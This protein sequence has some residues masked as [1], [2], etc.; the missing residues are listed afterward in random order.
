MR[1]VKICDAIMG[2]GKSQSAI[3]YMNDHPD[4]RFIYITPY[5]DEARRIK[6]GC[7]DLNFVEPR[8]DLGKYGFSKILHTKALLEERANITTTH[9]A[10][11][12]YTEEIADLIRNGG[13]TLMIDEAVDVF[14]EV[15]YSEGDVQLFL[16]SGYFT[17]EDGR[18]QFNGQEYTGSRLSD[19]YNMIRCNNLIKVD[20]STG[21][22]HFF[23]W[24]FPPNVICAFD[25]VIVMTYLFASS[26]LR[27][28]FDIHHMDY[29][30]IGIH[31]DG[32][33]YHFVDAPDYVPEYVSTLKDK[34]HIFDNPKLNEVGR[35][36][37]ALSANW[38]R[39]HT[40]E[41]RQLKNNIH[42]Y[43]Q[44]YQRARSADVMWSTFTG[45]ISSL[46]GKGYWNQDVVFNMKASNNYRD[47][48]VLAY[49]VNI[50]ASPRV[51][52]F[53]EKFG[54]KYDEDGRALSTMIQWIWR[55]AI[56]DGEEIYLYIPSSR[57]RRL[58]TDWINQVSE[59]GVRS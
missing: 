1:V 7:P 14:Q 24:T 21:S 55:S 22:S 16:D 48:H 57:M 44:N 12:W 39:T 45:S 53:F 32:S 5:L 34:I 35:R 25:D 59:G 4:K 13:Y 52:R 47:R 29:Q 17:Y 36:K 8:K 42:N 19:L 27:Y 37:Q 11:R 30:Y 51:V 43:F 23:Y 56:R 54:I 2:S 18:Y 33:S 10:F 31:R 58:L 41:K 3:S 46:R 15:K 38:F 9:S 40:D 28:F 50:F 20:G 26:E 6:D 49:C